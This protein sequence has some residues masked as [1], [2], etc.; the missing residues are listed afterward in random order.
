ML[1]AGTGAGRSQLLVTPTVP[2]L[3]VASRMRSHHLVDVEAELDALAVRLAGAQGAGEVGHADA[4]T[5]VAVPG[6][7]A[8]VLERAAWHS[9][10]PDNSGELVGI[11]NGEA[12]DRAVH[13]DRWQ[14]RWRSCRS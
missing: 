3:R 12:G 6:K 8:D 4:P 7:L 14:P 2:P 9:G 10:D 13:L 11:R 5:G 1:P